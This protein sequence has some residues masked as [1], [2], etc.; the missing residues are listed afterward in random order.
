MPDLQE[1]FD[2]IYDLLDDVDLYYHQ[3][4]DLHYDN[5]YR[6][7]KIR[8]GQRNYEKIIRILKTVN[9]PDPEDLI[10]QSMSLDELKDYL[11]TVLTIILGNSYKDDINIAAVFIT[12]KSYSQKTDVR[13]SYKNIAGVETACEFIVSKEHNPIQLAQIVNSEVTVL[14]KP[15]YK[16][17]ENTISN[18]HYQKFPGILSAYIAIY[19]LSKLLK[20]ESLVTDFEDYSVFNNAK[21]AKGV[22]RYIIDALPEYRRREV[23]EHNEHNNFSFIISD[24]YSSSLMEKYLEDQTSFLD[25]YRSMLK[26]SI[27]IPDYLDYYG[28]SLLDNSIVDNYKERISTV[29]K[30]YA[31][32]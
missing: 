11:K 30:R 23:R 9:I 25:K 4:N 12:A 31:L 10:K 7:Y 17:Y 26:G 1:L 13:T 29:E 22:G 32:K 8:L 5:S 16:N 6:E 20:Q 21:Y 15:L 28:L 14:L 19:E 24:I 2:I 3:V 27:S 18:I